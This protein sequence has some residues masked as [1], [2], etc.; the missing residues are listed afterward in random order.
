MKQVPYA[1]GIFIANDIYRIGAEL[2]HCQ[3][4]EKRL[5]GHLKTEGAEPLIEGAKARAPAWSASGTESLQTS[6]CKAGEGLMSPAVL[7]AG[8]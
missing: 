1:K 6:G 2:A 5:Q 7:A 3:I 4:S 8:E